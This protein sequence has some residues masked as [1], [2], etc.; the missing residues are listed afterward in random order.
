ML[1][2]RP[3]A[4]GSSLVIL[5][6][7]TTNPVHAGLLPTTVTITPDHGN[8]RWTYSVVLPSYTK[9]QDGNY[10]SIYDFNGL[11]PGAAGAP[12]GWTLS[13]PTVGPHPAYV[14]VL[15]NPTVSNLVWTY[16]GP[17]ILAGRVQLGDFWATSLSGSAEEGL[18]VG[19]NARSWDGLS[20]TNI[21]ETK[22]PTPTA[23]PGVPEPGTLILACTGLSV[24]GMV[25]RVRR[26]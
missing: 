3:M 20:D 16:H 17:T 25:R 13:T 11:V 21:T 8:F 9:L 19:S 23:P 18:F 24:L 6:A 2:P 7:L 4:F 26:P 14:T 1:L 15:D 22:V 5:T 10:F 12:A